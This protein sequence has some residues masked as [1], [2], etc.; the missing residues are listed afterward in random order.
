MSVTK[1]DVGLT[2]L[3]DLKELQPLVQRIPVQTSPPSIEE[4]TGDLERVRSQ[5][6]QEI[7]V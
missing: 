5:V 1:S 6:M 7:G 4:T 2:D 3:L